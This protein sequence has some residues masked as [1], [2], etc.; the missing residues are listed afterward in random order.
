MFI[1]YMVSTEDNSL[2]DKWLNNKKDDLTPYYYNKL[3]F[4]KLYGNRCRTQHRSFFD[5][6]CSLATTEDECIGGRELYCQ[7][8]NKQCSDVIDS[9]CNYYDDSGNYIKEKWGKDQVEYLDRLYKTGGIFEYGTVIYNNDKKKIDQTIKTNAFQKI[10]DKFNVGSEP[11]Y[12]KVG[13]FSSINN[14]MKTSESSG[15]FTKVPSIMTQIHDM[16]ENIFKKLEIPYD[17]NDEANNTVKLVEISIYVYEVLYTDVYKFK[18]KINDF[19]IFKHDTQFDKKIIEELQKEGIC[20]ESRNPKLHVKRIP[21]DLFSLPKEDFDDENT[22]FDV[23]YNVGKLCYDVA[24]NS[25]FDVGKF[26]L[27]IPEFLMKNYG[28][29]ILLIFVFVFAWQM[30]ALVVDAEPIVDAVDGVVYYNNILMGLFG[31]QVDNNPTLLKSM[32]LLLKPIMPTLNV[33][34][35]LIRDLL[36]MLTPL[37]ENPHV[38]QANIGMVLGNEITNM[39]YSK[40]LFPKQFDVFIKQMQN[41]GSIEVLTHILKNDILQCGK[42]IRA[43][44]RQ[45]NLVY[46]SD[47]ERTYQRWG[48]FIFEQWKGG[49]T[50]MTFKLFVADLLKSPLNN[51]GKMFSV[52]TAIMIPSAA[53]NDDIKIIAK[54]CCE[55]LYVLFIE[56]PFPQ[57]TGVKNL[58][59]AIGDPFQRIAATAISY[60]VYERFTAIF[61]CNVLFLIALSSGMLIGNK[62]NDYRAAYIKGRKD[63][64]DE[65]AA[66]PANYGR[67]AVKGKGGKGIE[68]M[69]GSTMKK[70]N[71]TSRKTTSRKKKLRKLRFRSPKSASA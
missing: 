57:E 13:C 10:Y 27:H 60:N 7:Y 69:K 25:V 12:N 22:Y 65:Y 1:K 49:T 41:I 39:Y 18:K 56:G 58:A 61:S 29:I 68:H 48:Q 8:S 6:S 52:L 20:V 53:K 14:L 71:A 40:S 30:L 64:N 54:E 28:I 51:I 5:A 9:I 50:H 4:L 46:V 37:L 66:N 19:F 2:L 17:R 33:L 42:N 11:G 55:L 67:N 62:L 36:C 44:G 16:R 32:I 38:I 15:F 24:I 63:A 34:Y 3:E 59:E 26:I 43:I 23:L 47:E 35:T 31:Y 70:S 45:R 21:H